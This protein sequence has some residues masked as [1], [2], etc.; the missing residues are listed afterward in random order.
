MAVMRHYPDRRPVEAYLG[1]CHMFH[2]HPH[3]QYGLDV[4]YVGWPG[5]CI[6]LRKDE[7]QAFE[8]LASTQ[9]VPSCQSTASSLMRK[10]HLVSYFGASDQSIVF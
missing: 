5:A 9:D 10:K 4:P 1:S 3:T 7:H 2:W 6:V 8:T